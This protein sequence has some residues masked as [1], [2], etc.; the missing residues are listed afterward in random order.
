MLDDF[1]KRQRVI[2]LGEEEE[3]VE[4][5]APEETASPFETPQYKRV[6]QACKER[7][8]IPTMAWT[9]DE[10]PKIDFTKDSEYLRLYGYE[11][12]GYTMFDLEPQTSTGQ[13]HEIP[14]TYTFDNGWG[15]MRINDELYKVDKNVTMHVQTRDC[16]EV[17][18]SIKGLSYRIKP[19]PYHERHVLDTGDYF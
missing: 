16:V 3:V 2:D 14:A 15:T 6:I 10:E 4:E 1:N 9:P 13:Q 8:E 19:Y 11:K 18:A 17:N 12:D 7:A 5:K